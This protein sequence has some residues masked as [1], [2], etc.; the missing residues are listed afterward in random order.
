[1]YVGSLFPVLV[2]VV[3]K[4][5]VIFS[6]IYGLG[7]DVYGF[8]RDWCRQRKRALDWRAILE[9]CKRDIEY[10]TKRRSLNLM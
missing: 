7:F 10:S 3:V 1:M 5:Q 2:V 6:M 9:P 8:K 4:I